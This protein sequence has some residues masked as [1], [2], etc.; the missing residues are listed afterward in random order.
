M[1]KNNINNKTIIYSA[2]SITLKGFIAFQKIPEIL[3]PIKRS[4]EII[5]IKLKA[6]SRAVTNNIFNLTTP[7][8]IILFLLFFSKQF[9][10][11]N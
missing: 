8:G 11:L 10:I 3:I 2:V 9:F 5:S 7:L 1:T 6:A 4:N